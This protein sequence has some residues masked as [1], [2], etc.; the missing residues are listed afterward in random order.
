[1]ALIDR[2]I[3][4]AAA[5]H[6]DQRRKYDGLPYITHPIHVMTILWDHGV[7]D[8][9]MLAA[10]VLHDVVED[11]PATI[12]DISA[13]FGCDVAELVDGLTD[14]FPAGTGGNRAERKAKERQRIAGTSMRC[15]AVKYADLISNTSSI[16]DHDPDF[17]RVYLKE[18]RAIVDSM[19]Q[20][21]WGLWATC[22]E[23][24]AWGENE[25]VQYALFKSAT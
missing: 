11:T 9:G 13:C 15:Q 10:A 22:E 23:K 3:A 20:D 19:G 5:A 4:F 21:D 17:A 24:L 16:V 25:L 8:E 14:K 2:A 1:M 18:K 6:T 12:E 7:R